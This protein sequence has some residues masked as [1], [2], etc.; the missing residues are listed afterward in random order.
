MKKFPVN[1]GAA[2]NESRE[3]WLC[4]QHKPLYRDL[5]VSKISTPLEINWME[6]ITNYSEYSFVFQNKC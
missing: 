6:S 3:G 4:N 2:Y 5:T 1:S